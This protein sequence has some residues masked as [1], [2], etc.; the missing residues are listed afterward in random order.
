MR[1]LKHLKES[2]GNIFVSFWRQ[3]IHTHTHI[4]CQSNSQNWHGFSL[5]TTHA[6][7]K[8]ASLSFLPPL[9]GEQA[10][11]GPCLM[12]SLWLAGWE[13]MQAIF[14][15]SWELL[16]NQCCLQAL[17][18]LPGRRK[19]GG[20]TGR[21]RKAHREW[22][23]VGRRAEAIILSRPNRTATEM[24]HWNQEA[25]FLRYKETFFARLSFC[26]V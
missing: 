5:K 8:R 15:K 14:L 22:W 16:S 21:W 2:T 24:L 26:G 7:S 23:V 1:I 10:L 25:G 20:G 3:K 4:R 6:N 18:S 17:I 9:W 12:G 19:P 11:G 13:G